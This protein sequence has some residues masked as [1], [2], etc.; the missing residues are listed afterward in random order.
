MLSPRW[1]KVLS[2][3]WGNK[4][5]T[6]LVVLSVAIGVFAIGAIVHMNLV[7]RD[8]LV[9]SYEAT[10]P[11]HA[12]LFLGNAV[13]EDFIQ[14][15]RKLDGVQEVEG[16]RTL[17]L[18]FRH[19]GQ[20]DWLPVQVF[21]IPNYKDIRINKVRPEIV[22]DP[23]PIRWP[24]GAWPPP[25][26]E[27]LL[28]R[29]SLLSPMVGLTQARLGDTIIVQTVDG[30]EREM[31]LAGLCYDFGRAPATFAGL[32]YAYV[33]FDTLEWLGGAR[34][35]DELT[36][37]VTG[38]A[39]DK[40]HIKR[41][42]DRVKERVERSGRLVV[43]AVVHE[44]GK[45][46]LDDVFQT[47]SLVLGG[48]GLF[49]LFLSGFLV[50]NTI[51]ALLAQQVRQIGVMKAVGA[52]N[53]QMIVMYMAV[54][55]IFGV[56][57]LLIAVPLGALAAREFV[58]FLA[59]FLNFKS[60]AFRIPPAVIVI[61]VVVGLLVPVLAALVPVI[62]GTR[63]TVREAI[64]SYGLGKGRFGSGWVDRALENVRGLPR[65]LAISLRNT[66]RR[67]GRLA[68][69]LIT[70][71]LGCAIFISV[72]SVRASLFAI[73]DDFLSYFSYDAQIV[74][75]RAHRTTQVDDAAR[76]VA[77]I[78][79][80]EY[81][82]V[83]FAYRIRA[84]GGESPIMQIIA[85]PVDTEMFK[86]QIIKGRWLLPDDENAIVLNTEVIKAE[87]DIDVGDEIVLRIEGRE[88]AWHVIGIYQG[89]SILGLSGHAN[90]DYFSRAVHRIPDQAAAIAVATE[91]HDRA[92][93]SSITKELEGRFKD[94]GIR[95]SG[96]YT[97]SQMR[98]QLSQLFDIITLLMSAMAMLVAAVGGLGL[99]GTMSI[100][101][102]ERTREIGVMRAVG[103]SNGAVRQ[104]IITEGVL[105][106]VLSWLLGVLLALPM[107]RL[108]SDAIGTGFLGSPLH[109][110]FSVEGALVCL[111]GVVLIAAAAS[112]LPA[113]NASRMTVREVLAYE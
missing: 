68:L 19:P 89:L 87:P 60:G 42:A 56:L 27:L 97:S 72:L 99:M 21:A 35:Y 2:D 15:V 5:R 77:G 58:G 79:K 112:F 102:L 30:H 105:I 20:D 24:T 25:E 94:A 14:A 4:T 22:Y 85:T 43:A 111:V 81:L 83:A 69:T 50:I 62:G 45:L 17:V 13:D 108:F 10:S 3:I 61:E 70:L 104:I 28:E 49:S 71:V 41:V 90:Y 6:L 76:D 16:R 52:R 39:Q 84:D 98:D 7:V 57:A 18:R 67:K 106:G 48:L 93:Q 36:I 113:W 40:A 92:S 64:S 44:P 82:D 100:N 107:G 74:F 86:P 46:P 96:I 38:D 66:F 55:L 53:G 31:R 75:T 80:L 65:P 54:V 110:T 88:M 109:Y 32:A 78:T 59:Y 95:L 1:R 23:D 26:H 63:I 11:A 34:N 37:R 103:A 51:S 101:V 12:T 91:R 8:D 73:V 9:E 29:T 47:I 33:T